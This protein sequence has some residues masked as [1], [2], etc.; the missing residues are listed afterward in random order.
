[1]PRP[2]KQSPQVARVA[3]WLESRLPAA[4]L[5]EREYRFHPA[6]RWR[7]DLAVP[8]LMLAFELEGGTWIGGR[9]TSGAGYEKDAEKYSVAAALGWAVIR[10]TTTQAR[11]GEVFPWLEWVIRRRDKSPAGTLVCHS[12]CTTGPL[13]G[14]R[15]TPT[16]GRTG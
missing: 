8:S 14:S 11:R 7:F 4:G 15:P 9:H 5:I 13:P 6:R 12:L 3:A 10:A 16:R 2:K 1:M